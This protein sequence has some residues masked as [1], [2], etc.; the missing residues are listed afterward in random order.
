M[1]QGKETI[2]QIAASN[3]NILIFGKSGTGKE[4]AALSIEIY[5]HHSGDMPTLSELELRYIKWV[6]EKCDGN[7]TRAA[8]IMGIDRVSLWRKMKRFRIE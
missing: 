4:P 2:R 7:K 5:R 3:A 6:L 8:E 1:V